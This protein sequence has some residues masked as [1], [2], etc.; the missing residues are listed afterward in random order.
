MEI[1]DKYCLALTPQWNLSRGNTRIELSSLKAK[2]LITYLVLQRAYDHNREALAALLWADGDQRKA[3]TS[4]RQIV[5]ILKK[6]LPDET[7][8][9][10]SKNAVGL[11]RDRFVTNIDL[12]LDE[13]DTGLLDADQ[14]RQISG[15]ATALSEFEEI[16]DEFGGWVRDTRLFLMRRTL[17]RLKTICIDETRPINLRLRVAE[18]AHSLDDLD[19]DAVR[20]LMRLHVARN[21]SVVALRIY[22]DFC[23]RL[24]VEL[25]AEPS[26]ETQDLAVQIKLAQDKPA[27]SAPALP[28]AGSVVTVAVLPFEVIGQVDVPEYVLL[29]LLDQITC[30]L[31]TLRAPAVISSN[32][33]RRYLGTAPEPSAVGQA[34]DASYVVS[35]TLRAQGH[36]VLISIQLAGSADNRLIWANTLTCSMQD[37]YNIKTPIAQD[38]VSAIAPSINTAELARTHTAP[39]TELEPYHLVLRAKDMIF[40]LSQPA[41][42]QAGDILKLAVT[43]SPHFAPAHALLAEWFTLAV[44]QGWSKDRNADQRAIDTHVRRAIS[45]SPGDG[46]ALALWGH[47][48]MILHREYDVALQAFDTALDLCPN[49][50]ETLVWSVPT[51]AYTGDA[52]RAIELGQRAVNLS[53]LDPFAF[54][55][56]HFLSLAH[57]SAGEYDR[58]ADLGLSSFRR[59]PSYSSN[60]RATIAALHASDRLD[61]A[62]PLLTH[63]RTIEPDFSL[64]DYYGWQGFRSNSMR[65]EFCDRLRHAG[66]PA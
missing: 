30:E 51:L 65:Q 34:L 60:I 31:A 61:E 36:D 8:F 13:I 48:R 32:T 17:D 59:A 39:V 15:L 52:A 58:S 41:F 49:D 16:G 42:A 2:A 27:V 44:W 43:N 24:E 1:Q 64:D 66:I 63:H 22:G 55:N 9:V 19:E 18:V 45:L 53:P 7:A 33:T 28:R 38:V 62:T 46:R 54:R 40:Q 23:A 21:N 12:V 26:I 10:H 57:Y 5:A 11:N 47:S 14:M 25:D 6:N 3:R 56:E 4:L 50:S 29:G 37:V 35:G 20:A